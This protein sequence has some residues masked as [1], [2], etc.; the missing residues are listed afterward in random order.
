MKPVLIQ[1]IVRRRRKEVMQNDPAGQDIENTAN[2]IVN[3]ILVVLAVL[4]V[5]SIAFVN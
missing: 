5:G 1:N 4:I 2:K 3:S